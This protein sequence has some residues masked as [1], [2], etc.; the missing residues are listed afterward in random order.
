MD[1][2][3]CLMSSPE[4]NLL[5]DVEIDNMQHLLFLVI[6]FRPIDLERLDYHVVMR[7]LLDFKD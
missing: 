1:P 4:S 2:D 6:V 3:I 5:S 7:R